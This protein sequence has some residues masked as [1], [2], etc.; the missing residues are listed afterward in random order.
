MVYTILTFVFGITTL[1]FGYATFNLMRKHEQ[2]ED[3]VIALQNR[4]GN[5]VTE[6]KEIDEKGIFEAD[7]EVGSVF[8]QLSNITL[9]LESFTEE[10]EN[11][12]QS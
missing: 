10:E 11:A 3:W 9:T 4:V 2:V 1:G 6:M 5:V 8:K 12:T 7:D